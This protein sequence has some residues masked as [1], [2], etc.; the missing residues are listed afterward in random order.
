MDLFDVEAQ[1]YFPCF[2]NIISL[3]GGLPGSFTLS[4]F[5]PTFFKTSKPMKPTDFLNKNVSIMSAELAVG[6]GGSI[7]YLTIWGVD[8]DPFWLD[9]GGLETGI[10]GGIGKSLGRMVVLPTG[11]KNEGEIIAPNS[12]AASGPAPNMTPNKDPL[13]GGQSFRPPSNSAMSGGN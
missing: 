9:I 2:I 8:H 4:T 13:S 12:A 3:G 6:I 10:A 7:A 5:S 11:K 1:L